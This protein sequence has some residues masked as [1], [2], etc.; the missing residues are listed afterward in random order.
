MTD[1]L[2]ISTRPTETERE[3]EEKRKGERERK[4]GRVGEGEWERERERGIKWEVREGERKRWKVVREI[5]RGSER[6]K[7]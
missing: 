5:F 1:P 6:K 4:S 7:R 2:I 3:E